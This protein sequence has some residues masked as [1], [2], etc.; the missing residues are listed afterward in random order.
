VDAAVVAARGGLPT[1]P[2]ELEAARRDQLRA[3]LASAA[4]LP[5]LTDDQQ[6]RRWLELVGADSV[7]AWLSG[8]STERSPQYVRVAF[9]RGADSATPRRLPVTVAVLARDAPTSLAGL[10]ADSARLR[11]RL[12]DAGSAP[13][14]DPALRQRFPVVVAWVMPANVF[15]DT[16]WPGGDTGSAHERR[17]ARRAAA[18]GWLAERGIAIATVD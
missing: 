14:A 10:L 18:A 12:D 2:A 3:I 6:L 16:D 5:V 15:D 4:G 13:P 9:D 8:A 17:L 11:R 1:D 7:G